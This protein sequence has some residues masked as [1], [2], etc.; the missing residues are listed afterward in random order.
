MKMN[1]I[2]SMLTKTGIVG[3]GLGAGL[4]LSMCA[5][6]V[7]AAEQHVSVTGEIR[8]DLTKYSLSD[9]WDDKDGDGMTTEASA[10]NGRLRTLDA[11]TAYYHFVIK[12]EDGT[13]W[14]DLD[15]R[16][17]TENTKNAAKNGEVGF[18]RAPSFT[19]LND[20]AIKEDNSGKKPS[21]GAF[22]YQQGIGI[23]GLD[24]DSGSVSMTVPDLYVV[25]KSGVDASGKRVT[26]D[27]SSHRFK[28]PKLFDKVTVTAAKV[29]D[30]SVSWVGADY[31]ALTADPDSLPIG[32]IV[33]YRVNKT[34][35]FAE[36]W[37]RVGMSNTKGMTLSNGRVFKSGSRILGLPHLTGQFAG[38]VSV[39]TILPIVK[40]YSWMDKGKG[41]LL[42][43]DMN[44][45]AIDSSSYPMFRV[46]QK[47]EPKG[48]EFNV[49]PETVG[50]PAGTN[51]SVDVRTVYDVTIN[52]INKKG[53]TVNSAKYTLRDLTTSTIGGNPV[54]K[55]GLSWDLDLKI[56]PNDT[57]SIAMKTYTLLGA[58]EQIIYPNGQIVQSPVNKVG[59]S[60]FSFIK[61]DRNYFLLNKI[62][63][64]STRDPNRFGV[65]KTGIYSQNQILNGVESDYTW[66]TRDDLVNGVVDL[67]TVSA[68]GIFSENGVAD[69]YFDS[70]SMRLNPDVTMATIRNANGLPTLNVDI[71]KDTLFFAVGGYRDIVDSSGNTFRIVPDTIN[72]DTTYT[73]RKNDNMYTIGSYVIAPSVLAYQAAEARILPVS[74]KTS[75]G[76]FTDVTKPTA[77]NNKN[78]ADFWDIFK[79][80][81]GVQIAFLS[82]Y[83]DYFLNSHILF[84]SS[85]TSTSVVTDY[86]TTFIS[87]YATTYDYSVP[88]EENVAFSSVAVLSPDSVKNLRIYDVPVE[89]FGRVTKMPQTVSG[90]WYL[91]LGNVL[92]QSDMEFGSF[93][94]YKSTALNSSFANRPYRS[95]ALRFPTSYGIAKVATTPKVNTNDEKGMQYDIIPYN[96]ATSSWPKE[97]SILD[98]LPYDGD[99]RGSKFSGSYTTK[100][101]TV[102]DT[103]GNPSTK[104]ELYYT[105]KK[106]TDSLENQDVNIN[107]GSWTKYTGQKNVKMT[108]IVAKTAN[109]DP[110]ERYTI[111]VTLVPQGNVDGDVYV[112]HAKM[113]SK[114]DGQDLTIPTIN[115][116][117]VT[118]EIKRSIK[119]SVFWDNLY[120]GYFE[121]TMDAFDG[122]MT[123]E[124]YPTGD[125]SGQ[126]VKTGI[127]KDGQYSIDYLEPG[128]YDLVFR[129]KAFDN[130]LMLTKWIPV[131]D[132]E[133]GR[134]YNLGTIGYDKLPQISNVVI[135]ESP[136]A[137]VTGQNIGVINKPIPTVTKTV[138]DSADKTTNLN[139]GTIKVGQ[140][141]YYEIAVTNGQSHSVMETLTVTDKLPKGL[142]LVPGSIRVIGTDG[143]VTSLPDDIVKNGVLTTTNLGKLVDSQTISVGF[144]V[145]VGSDA[146][147]E[148]VNT[149]IAKATL[150]G[151]DAEGSGNTSSG[152]APNMLKIHFAMGR[153]MDKPGALTTE[154]A[155]SLP[156]TVYSQGQQFQVLGLG[157]KKS[158]EVV[159]YLPA[160]DA[161]TIQPSLDMFYEQDWITVATDKEYTTVIEPTDNVFSVKGETELWVFVSNKRSSNVSESMYSLTNRGSQYDNLSKSSPGFS[162]SK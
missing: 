138:W 144:S 9:D 132:R 30:F 121:K 61:W 75:N 99:S 2:W 119:G 122:E 66:Y 62:P 63:G 93:G 28:L 91:P 7:K 109:I 160:T 105:T 97:V 83:E 110:N 29:T 34:V 112:N 18:V 95:L 59:E 146:D 129:S 156:L 22:D 43:P 96:F 161:I 65:L 8:N 45:R 136:K 90:E 140:T 128:E 26:F 124:A 137:S 19:S 54:L 4:G 56:K 47:Y 69:M 10:K 39:E 87:D 52:D 159:Y 42:S 40:E 88:L 15:M 81:G 113:M 14:S 125:F 48:L 72:D 162:L 35:D 1:K 94:S 84:N 32:D 104:F 38:N 89:W 5:E 73:D 143:T 150:G 51:V 46:S 78:L 11:M 68:M 126:P 106:V 79:I 49:N 103:N 152:V 120:D 74:M 108:A 25:V 57:F 64:T 13:N 21:I 44:L 157:D 142:T 17:E 154:H 24:A 20:F 71:T 86:D 70:V 114:V 151:V 98:V 135:G 153:D 107:D 77:D 3:L 118:E 12:S 141:M 6:E 134:T 37:V 23:A 85:G 33:S 102:L 76:S 27:E 127:V 139:G 130:E 36:E 145:T 101:I 158:Y 92:V 53:D 31:R 60:G 149:A 147:A 67:D 115:A 133:S 50:L 82:A 155:Q 41:R 123:V 116:T 117:V 131:S 148:L 55:G 100:D 16:F 111:S 58:V 80:T